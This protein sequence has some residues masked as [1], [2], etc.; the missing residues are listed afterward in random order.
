MISNSRVKREV[1]LKNSTADPADFVEWDVRNWSVAL[2]FW[3]AHTRQNASNCSAL[4]L[5]S[6]NGGLSLWLA[7]QGARV[8]C[9]DIGLPTNHAMQ[10][11]R[12]RGVSHLIQYE[13]IDASHIPYENKFDIIVFKSLLGAVGRGDN[14][15]FQ[16]GAVTEM[17]KALKQGG[18][19]FFAENLIASPL[20]QSLRR[21][22]VQWGNTW[23]YVSVAEMEEFLSRFSHVRYRTLG[24][25]GAF[26]RGEI[27]R[28]L[29]GILDQTVLNHIVPDNWRYIIVGVATK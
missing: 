16:A 2:D 1:R 14:R 17:H 26:G 20:H 6:R 28:H 5:G 13:S 11:H 10:Q 8:L 15:Q 12:A 25:A 9:S 3:S 24:C 23:R 29:F 4:E 7:L 18:E 21:R 27:Q 19:L 22:F